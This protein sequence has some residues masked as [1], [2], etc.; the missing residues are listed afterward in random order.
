MARY[1]KANADFAELHLRLV[2]QVY[3]FAGETNDVVFVSP[4]SN[5]FYT[6]SILVKGSMQIFFPD[7]NDPAIIA[8][9]MAKVWPAEEV[10][11]KTKVSSITLEDDT[12]VM[13]IQPYSGYKTN[14]TD[15]TLQVSG[16]LIVDV[17][18][19]LFVSGSNYTINDKTYTDFNVF[20]VQNAPVNISAT[21]SCR[22]I[23][24]RAVPL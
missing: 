21:E 6:K 13:C 4:M 15:T 5:D 7:S 22:A 9:G 1:F 14:H 24:F 2:E 18:N 17:G 12:H 20:A 3:E 10:I 11:G 19:L 16:N 8:K 23:V